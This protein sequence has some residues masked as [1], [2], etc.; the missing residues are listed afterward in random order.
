M[1]S[2]VWERFEQTAKSCPDR[3]AIV[4]GDRQWSFV[5]LHAQSLTMADFFAKSGV[6]QSARVLLWMENR[7]EMAAALLG[8]WAIGGVAVLLNAASPVS[9]LT[10]AASVTEASLCVLDDNQPNIIGDIGIPILSVD[11]LSPTP[12]GSRPVNM[13]RN[14]TNQPA[15]VV[16]TSGSTGLPKGVIQSHQNLLIGCDTIY[17]YMGYQSDDKIVCPIPWSFDYGFGQL[18]TTLCCGLTHILPEARNSFGLCTA[19][20]TYSPT[21]LPGIPSLFTGLFHGISPLMTTDISSL[22]LVTNTGGTIPQS[23]LEEMLEF[24][25]DANIVLNYGLTET[26]RS[27][28]LHPDLTRE[29][30]DSIGK[31]MPG[32]D[33]VVVRDDGSVASPREIG[34][35]VHRGNCIFRGYWNDPEATAQTLR[36][37]PLL[38][39]GDANNGPPAVFTGDLG[40]KDEAGF[41]YYRGRRDHL[42]KTMGI[43][44]SPGEIEAL[45]HLSGLVRDVAVF[46][47]SSEMMGDYVAAAVEPLVVDKNPISALK[48]FAHGCMSPQMQPREYF[49]FDQIPKNS[50]GK[51]DYESLRSLCN[52]EKTI[53]H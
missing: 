3:V 43:R 20:Q 42:I 38:P 22:R 32:V 7:P 26:Y 23:V 11:G 17:G 12:V 6:E 30:P 36:K 15:S 37:D 53:R 48:K 44:V 1:H 47:L 16:F 13:G 45:L 14:S 35:I 5:D 19:I 29:R 46:G 8:T 50:N 2:S 51:T 21:I 34:E 9:H 33:I 41:L 31:P 49:L 25:S 24:F 18:L 40:Y 27:C 28:Y 39:S 52:K 10:H 4:Q